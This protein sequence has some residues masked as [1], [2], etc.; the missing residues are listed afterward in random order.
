MSEA[1]AD[2]KFS[3]ENPKLLKLAGSEQ[4]IKYLFSFEAKK[5]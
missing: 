4:G 3:E 2:M 5:I 1:R